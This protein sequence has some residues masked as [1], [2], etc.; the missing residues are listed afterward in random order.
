[1]SKRF[2]FVAV[3]ILLAVSPAFVGAQSMDVQAQIAALQAQINQLR[4]LLAQ[5]QGNI[6]TPPAP[7]ATP[8]TLPPA[9]PFSCVDLE[10]NLG[11]DDNDADTSGEVTKLQRYLS[12]TGHYAGAISGHVGPRTARAIQAW[13]RAQ[14]LVS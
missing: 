10:Y 3:G 2:A 1:M 5:L 11:A 4:A 12:A 13:Q 8:P 14:G 9:P 7:P 6:S